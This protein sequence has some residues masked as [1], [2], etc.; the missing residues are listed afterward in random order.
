M[1]SDYQQLGRVKTGNSEATVKVIGLAKITSV[2]AEE[3]VFDLLKNAHIERKQLS[4]NIENTMKYEQSIIMISAIQH[5]AFCPRQFALIHIEQ[6]WHENQFTAEGNILHERVDSG[7][8]EQRN[9]IRYERG[10]ALKSEQYALVGKM[11]LLEIHSG[12]P[13]QYLPVEYKRGKPKVLDW[14][15]VQVCA[16]ALCIEEMRDTKIQQ[17]AIWYW[18]V[19]QREH[20]PL[21]NELRTNTIQIIQAAHETYNAGV[22]PP[23]TEHIK[24]CRACS[25]KDLCEPETFRSDHSRA[26][27]DNMFKDVQ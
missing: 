12:S 5:Y 16:Q 7:A 4:H 3:G 25:L 19:R 13:P 8:A 1:A 18:Q 2:E 11:D 17:A 15:R 24:R 23:P 10:V 26:Y 9:D 20:F 14:D 6:L 22:T 21:N 27:V